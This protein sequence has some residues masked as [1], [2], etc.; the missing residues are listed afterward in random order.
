MRK[1]I[2]AADLAW[3]IGNSE[4]EN[5]LPWESIR[6]DFKHFQEESKIAYYAVMG[7]S[8]FEA[9]LN[10]SKGK[11]LPGR[12]IVVVSKTLTETPHPDVVL[13]SGVEEVVKLLEGKDFIV[14]GGKKTYESFLPIIDEIIFTQIH[15]SFVAD[16]SI[17]NTMFNDFTEDETRAKTL[18]EK[19]ETFPLV[20]AHY[21]TR[22]AA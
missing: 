9:I 16:C 4:N 20:T 17:S 8:T 3:G 18:K 11:L 2:L 15:G 22:K 19:T 1:M 5:G 14:C 7:R 13:C 21:F 10:F 6:E 12:K